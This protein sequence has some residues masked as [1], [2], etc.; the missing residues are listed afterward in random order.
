MGKITK[1]SRN[2]TGRRQFNVN[3]YSSKTRNVYW[4]DQKSTV[5]MR[6]FQICTLSFYGSSIYNLFSKEV[7]RIYTTYNKLVRTTFSVPRETHRYFIEELTKTLHIKVLFCSRLIKFQQ[8]LLNSERRAINFL[9]KMNSCDTRTTHGNNLKK[10][11]MNCD[12][13]NLTSQLVKEKMKYFQIPSTEE[14]KME[15]VYELIQMR[16]DMDL[17]NYDKTNLDQMLNLLMTA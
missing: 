4:K 13:T 8:M 7:N 9:A 15:I 17:S 11:E 12:E 14:W 5:K 2:D 1:A 16:N 6:I 10:I 3:G